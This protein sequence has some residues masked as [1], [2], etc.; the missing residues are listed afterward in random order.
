M[1]SRAFLT[2]HKILY[3][4]AEGSVQCAGNGSQACGNFDEDNCL[5]WAAIVPC[6]DGEGCSNGSC[7][8]SCGNECV[9]GATRCAPGG[10]QTCGNN[11]ADA[12]TDW[13]PAVACA[14]AQVCS[15]GTCS[16]TCVDECPTGAARCAA[17]GVETCGNF[18]GDDCAEWSLASPCP[19]NQFCSSGA[20]AAA[21]SDECVAGSV[22]CAGNGFETCGEF[23][24]DNC[25]E[26]SPVQPCQDG[27][28]C[29][30]GVCSQF[31]SNECNAGSTRCGGAGVQICGNFDNDACQDWGPGVPCANGQ[32]CDGGR[33]A[34]ACQDE[35]A[36]NE[37]RCEA[38]G[39]QSCGNFDNDNCREW[40]GSTAC[41]GGQICADGACENLVG[42]CQ[43]D[44]DCP[45]GL[46]CL[47]NFCVPALACADDSDCPAGERCDVLGGSIC[48]RDTPSGVGAPCA[49]DADCVDGLQC[50]NA[51]DGGYCTEGCAAGFPC[52]TGATCYV[53]DENTP[54][55]GVCLSDCASNDGCPGNQACFATGGLLGG[56]CFLAECRNDRD[57]GADP[58]IQSTCDA[59]LCVQN[60][61][62]DLATGEGCAAGLECW[63]HNGVG[64]CLDGCNIFSD[65]N[66]AAGERC[67]PV[68]VD[69]GGYCG[70]VGVAGLSELCAEQLDCGA[71]LFCLDDGVG[72]LSCRTL[73]NTSDA[74]ACGNGGEVCVSL[75]GDVG[76]CIVECQSE[77]N[78][79]ASRCTPQGVQ[80]CGQTNDDLC[81]EWLPA[82]ACGAGLGCS[83]LS[84]TCEP[85]CRNNADCADPIIPMACVAG[86]CKVQS[87]CDPA[88]GVGCQAPAECNLA[89]D[90]GGG[91]CLQP[92]DPLGAA[93]GGGDT[94]VLLGNASLC[95]APGVVP[96]GGACDAGTDCVAGAACL[97]DDTGPHCYTLCNSQNPGNI[98]AAGSACTDLG[99]DDRLG[100]CVSACQDECL[101]GTTLC[102]ADGTGVQ[103]CGEFDG[104]ACL[105]LS[106]STGCENETR[107]NPATV[108]C[109]YY[110]D[111]D[112]HCPVGFGVPYACVDNACVA[113][114]CRVGMD[115]CAPGVA[116]TVCIPADPA[117]PAAGLC[118]SNC[119]PLG[120]QPCGAFG[121]CDYVGAA[122]DTLEFVCL[123][124]GGAGEFE[125]CEQD[126]CQAG[127][128]C[129][130]FDDGAGGTQYNCVFFCD[131]A[132]G[133][134]ECAGRM[135]PT[136]QAVPD[137]G[138]NVGVC[139]P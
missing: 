71:N 32:I 98:C 138:A 11:D 29:S 103:T 137:F 59:G 76:V 51:A 54:D 129:L 17:N 41:A 81:L 82:A 96:V 8:A 24:G 28:S 44:A 127:L 63:Q 25:L 126:R 101:A 58:L 122:N 65:A 112:A 73:C 30:A 121:G 60:N 16:A 56:A 34:G 21:C 74:N 136:C 36:A 87:E 84:G 40:S 135:G 3:A 132:R 14:G 49:G 39:V 50:V 75:G 53:F 107:C 7:S 110:C 2:R 109:E 33:C 102:S 48:R 47:F 91:V 79:G 134:A 105:D 4:T 13:G 100:A 86:A 42:G 117:N 22:Q 125:A 113:R 119:D 90:S 83:D 52:P 77:C 19:A 85:A 89:T 69:G 57:C 67:S 61:G 131:S 18:D 70:P 9:N 38:G 92:C 35:C 27:T 108:A 6:A 62:C 114:D 5:E 120:N 139:T 12:C 72:N 124:A 43:A 10:V 1:K 130:P 106:P 111:V 31:C 104:D 94:C 88:T 55:Q 128:G 37:A 64:V 78:A 97:Q 115:A 45:G 46:L 23:D 95:L 66:C 123:P 15:N 118:L 93:C 116:N 26:W 20:C 68:S 99:I 133:D 80:T